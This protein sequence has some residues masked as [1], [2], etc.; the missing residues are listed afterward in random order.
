VKDTFYANEYKHNPQ[1][2][3]FLSLD[4]YLEWM[5]KIIELLN[6][7]IVVERIASEVPP[8]YLIAPDWGLIRNQ[9]ILRRFE[10]LL[11]Q[12]NTWQGKKWKK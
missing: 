11:E 9:E 7:A 8:W 12:Q 3:H 10:S 2:F 6:P 5:V 1:K 4:E